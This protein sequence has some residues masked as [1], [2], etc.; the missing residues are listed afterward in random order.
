MF[1]REERLRRKRESERLRRLANPELF[2]ARDRVRNRDPKR[3]A[4]TKAYNEGYYQANADRLKA[5]VKSYREANPEAVKAVKVRWYAQNPD[6]ASE[7]AQ[8][9]RARKKGAFVETVRRAVIYARDGWVCQLCGEPVP[10]VPY[11]DPLSPS[12]DHVIPLIRG[13]K[14]APDNVQL[15]HLRCNLRKGTKV[16]QREEVST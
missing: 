8:R 10:K 14:H 4:Y 16:E 15:A 9:R 3:R 7:A 12:L 5:D 6:R 2:K 1:D 11:P 13:G